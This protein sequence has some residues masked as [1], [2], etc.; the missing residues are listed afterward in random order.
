MKQGKIEVRLYTILLLLCFPSFHL[1]AFTASAPYLQP[2]A[3][4]FVSHGVNTSSDDKLFIFELTLVNKETGTLQPILKSVFDRKT[5]LSAPVYAQDLAFVLGSDLKIFGLNRQGKLTLDL[6]LTALSPKLAASRWHSDLLHVSS[7]SILFGTIPVLGGG[8]FALDL[9]PPVALMWSKALPEDTVTSKPLAVKLNGEHRSLLVPT[10]DEKRQH[11]ALLVLQAK[12]GEIIKEIS[13]SS[14]TQQ[15]IAEILAV[16]TKN[17]G[18]ADRAFVAGNDGIWTIDLESTWQ[19]HKLYAG[20]ASHLVCGRALSSRGMILY[21]VENNTRVV[22]LLLSGMGRE[23]EVLFA[24]EENKPTQLLLRQGKLIVSTPDNIKV[25]DGYTGRFIREQRLQPFF[26][27]YTSDKTVEQKL[28]RDI[29]YSPL[30]I[31]TKPREKNRNIIVKTPVGLS[32]GQIEIDDE[33]LGRKTFVTK[34]KR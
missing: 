5:K 10:H 14:H 21:Y 7:Q 13:I 23:K 27:F 32:L 34:V 30:M 24:L 28:H 8:V 11:N 20:N 22:A 17:T 26:N 1:F 33:S 29:P 6:D 19:V 15:P 4:L 9:S 16:D 2:T 18:V 31:L 25:F 3:S 12:T